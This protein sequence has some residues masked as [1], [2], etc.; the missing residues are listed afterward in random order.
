MNIKSLIILL[1]NTSLPLTTSLFLLAVS[2]ILLI[3]KLNTQLIEN[4]VT[5]AY[6]FLIL[7]IIMQWIDFVIYFEKWNGKES[8]LQSNFSKQRKKVAKIVGKEKKKLLFISLG[9]LI[10]MLIITGGIIKKAREDI[11]YREL[12]SQTRHTS[13]DLVII[14]KK[15]P[16]SSEV[17]EEIA[18]KLNKNGFTNINFPPEEQEYW[19]FYNS[20]VFYPPSFQEQAQKIHEVLSGFFKEKRIVLEEDERLVNEIEVVLGRE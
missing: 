10:F 7:G 5:L 15:G 17:I 14:F 13:S 11:Y 18:E 6:I 4:I 2:S 16:Y 9:V 8:F 19:I 3:F 12:L 20:Y 1:K